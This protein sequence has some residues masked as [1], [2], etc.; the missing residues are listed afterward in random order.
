MESYFSV[1]E[2]L[3][4]PLTDERVNIG[5]IV[6]GE[7]RARSRFLNNWQRVKAFSQ[8]DTGFLKEFARDVEKSTAAQLGL[9]GIGNRPSL[10]LADLQEISRSWLNAIQLTE[11]KASLKTPDELLEL[12][13]SRF[14]KEPRREKRGFRDRRAAASLAIRHVAT[15]L[16]ARGEGLDQ[17]VLKKQ[18]V[19]RGK[20][21]EHCFDVAAANGKP[22]FAA[23]ALSFETPDSDDLRKDID[24][25]LWALDDVRNKTKRLPLAVVA[26]PPKGRS[27]TFARAAKVF[28]ALDARLVT[29]ETVSGWA[30]EVAKR[31]PLR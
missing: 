8:T 28:E 13:A 11:P 18:F 31:V 14:L 29:D 2:Y 7:G 20:L 30:T 16:R 15:A 21:D 22:F 19:I 23:R 3:P 12:V 9:P 17:K 6:F 1:V 27:S 5:V 25:T 26:L 24:S 4:D 10:D